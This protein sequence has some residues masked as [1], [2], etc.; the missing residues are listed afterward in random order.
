VLFGGERL[1]VDVGWQAE[2]DLT[3][4]ASFRDLRKPV[5]ALNEKRLAGWKARFAEMP[6]PKFLCA[7]Y[8]HHP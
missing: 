7:K 3:N 2:L 4:P 8:H 1:D 6:E 5:G